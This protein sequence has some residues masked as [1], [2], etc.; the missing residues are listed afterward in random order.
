MLEFADKAFKA[1]IKTM[2]KDVK[3]NMLVMNETTD[4]LNRKIE[5]IKIKQV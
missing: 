5:I 1:A 2:L 4:I 3:A